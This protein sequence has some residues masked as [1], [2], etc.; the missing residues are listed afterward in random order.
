MVLLERLNRVITQVLLAGAGLAIVS[1]VILVFANVVMRQVAGS[2]SGVPEIVGWL[3]AVATSFALAYSQQRKAH[4]DLDIV[5]SRFPEVVQRVLA[6]LVAVGTLAFFAMVTWALFQYGQSV[7]ERGG[8][9]QT[10][11]FPFYPFIFAVSLGMGAF[12]LVLLQDCLTN[13]RAVWKNGS[14][15]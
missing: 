9:S 10:L 6:A 5:T 2:L 3:T 14:E 4:I 7:M 1:L 13:L 8:L 15:Q 11:R 12:C